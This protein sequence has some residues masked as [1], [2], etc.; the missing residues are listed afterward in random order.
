MI[1][2]GCEG[3]EFGFARQP[4]ILTDLTIDVSAGEM[5]AVTGAS[6]RGKSTLLHLLGLLLT[7]RSGRVLA[8]G[9]PVS[10]LPDA[11]RAALRGQMLGFVF[12]DAALD[13]TRTVMD[14]IVEVSLYSDLDPAAAR[15]R[16]SVLIEALGVDVPPN[17][18]P[19]QVSG[20][21]A[22]R[23]ALCRA[24]VHD[25]PVLL[26]DEPTGNL[27]EAS[28]AGVIQAMRGHADSGHM[29]VV[30]THDPRLEQSCDRSV[31]L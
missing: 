26:A 31:G 23:I 29:V 3:L 16:A 12:Q 17:R 13:G 6:G 27:D 2:F 11:R 1:S 25:P 19:G 4:S 10:G 7:P 28:A 20:G 18:R 22:Q 8:D 24:L 21:Q 30:A 5:V 15:R 9:T 14:N